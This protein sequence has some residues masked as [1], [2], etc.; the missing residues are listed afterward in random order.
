MKTYKINI[1]KDCEYNKHFLNLKNAPIEEYY[2]R[3]CDIY[4]RIFKEEWL[5][6]KK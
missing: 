4:E 1:C 3:I 5:F 6:R 2:S